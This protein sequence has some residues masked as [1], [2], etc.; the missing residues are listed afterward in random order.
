MLGI[1]G[2]HYGAVSWKTEYFSRGFFQLPGNDH[3]YRDWKEWGHGRVNMNKAVIESCDT[4]F[5]DMAVRLG[6]DQMSEGMK[7]FGFGRRQGR[8]IQGDLP[9]ILPSREWKRTAKKRALVFG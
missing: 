1:V 5:Y 2:L 6:I 4:Y 7:S 9:G 8:D 3:K